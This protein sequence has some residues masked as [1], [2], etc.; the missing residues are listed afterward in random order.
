M[1]DAGGNAG[2]A[3]A[4]RAAAAAALREGLAAVLA[5]A[6]A[7]SLCCGGRVSVHASCCRDRCGGTASS[8]MLLRLLKLHGSSAFI[9]PLREPSWKH[10]ACTG[11]S[12]QCQRHG[13]AHKLHHSLPAPGAVVQPGAHVTVAQQLRHLG[14]RRAVAVSAA[15]RRRQPCLPICACPCTPATFAQMALIQLLRPDHAQRLNHMRSS[16]SR[17]FATSTSKCAIAPAAS[18]PARDLIM[19]FSTAHPM[20]L[21][22]HLCA[23]SGLLLRC[24]GCWPR[25]CRQR[26]LQVEVRPGP[27]PPLVA[28]VRA[29]PQG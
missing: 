24:S 5:A 27:Q 8:S 26:V 3:G 18:Q 10:C 1:G 25:G 16:A 23:R 21:H 7:M 2:G 28:R 6:A 13:I 12:C 20:P 4:A 29:L 11:L 19:L 9:Q 14:G 22:L 17:R 15:V